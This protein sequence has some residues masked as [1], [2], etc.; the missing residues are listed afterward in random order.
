MTHLGVCSS[1]QVPECRA[2]VTS[3]G[4]RADTVLH[5]ERKGKLARI[6]LQ[7]TPI[8]P[9]ASIPTII[10]VRKLDGYGA[11]FGKDSTMPITDSQ[12]IL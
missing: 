7:F 2:L 10:Q 5:L 6:R 11:L 8:P 1:S 3:P 9:A 4:K 12:Q